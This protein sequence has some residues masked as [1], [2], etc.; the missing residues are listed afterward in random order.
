[1]IPINEAIET[2]AWLRADFRPDNSLEHDVSNGG[3]V[4]FRFR[5][6][7]FSKI[8][9]SM[10]A[11]YEDLSVGLDSNIW[12]LDVDV[13]NLNK[14]EMVIDVV[15]DR[16]FLADD[17]GFEFKVFEDAHLSLHSKFDS[18]LMAFY[19]LRLPPKIKRAGA[20]TYELPDDFEHGFLI[21]RNGELREA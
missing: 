12:K 15:R 14:K 16:L 11:Q 10:V 3:N 13:V 17:E 4:S 8:D 2:G 1:M 5:V 7:G 20:Y 9:L 18:R 21:I 6:S 19:I